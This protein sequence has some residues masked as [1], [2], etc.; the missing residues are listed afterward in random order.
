MREVLKTII[1]GVLYVFWRWVIVP[2]KRAYNLVIR[3]EYIEDNPRNRQIQ[4]FCRRIIDD[5]NCEASNPV[6]HWLEAQ[7][8]RQYH[9][10]T[11]KYRAMNADKA[12]LEDQIPDF[13][14]YRAIVASRI[15]LDIAEH[16]FRKTV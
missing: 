4:E 6:E 10:D 8:R 13:L 3:R 12:A 15:A 1:L 16:A 7:W 9:A 14:T 5:R 11:E 2:V